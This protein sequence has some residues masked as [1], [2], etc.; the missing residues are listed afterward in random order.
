MNTPMSN[1]ETKIDSPLL[2]KTFLN[3][4]TKIK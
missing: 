3:I 2:K 4:S 1:K